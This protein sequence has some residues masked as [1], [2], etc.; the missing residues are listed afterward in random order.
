MRQPSTARDL[1]AWHRSALAGDAPPIHDGLPEPGW[2]R[3]RLV[4]GGPFVPVRIYVSREIDPETGELTAPE[5]T[6]AESNGEQVNAAAIW[7]H[8]EPISRADYEALLRL[9]ASTP[10]MAATMIKMDLT[11]KA[12][13]P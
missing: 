5:L 7:T 3:R 9:C 6:L 1:Y 12:P 8:L 11:Q 2:Y 4:K 10:E 13:R